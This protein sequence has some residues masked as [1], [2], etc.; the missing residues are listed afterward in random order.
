[1]DDGHLGYQRPAARLLPMSPTQYRR[2]AQESE[3]TASV[4]KSRP[5]CS[6]SSDLPVQQVSASRVPLCDRYARVSRGILHPQGSQHVDIHFL[7][8]RTSAGRAEAENH[9]HNSGVSCDRGLVCD[10]CASS[11]PFSRLKFAMDSPCVPSCSMLC[12]K[13]VGPLARP[14]SEHAIAGLSTQGK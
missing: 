7:E 6:S 1:M 8:P 13:T 3:C 11:I 9:A 10:V 5:R 4:D 12:S 14:R 2:D